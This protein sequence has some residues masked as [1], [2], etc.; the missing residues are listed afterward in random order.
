MEENRLVSKT[1]LPDEERMESALRPKFLSEYIG[2]NKAKEKLEIF[3][4][5]AKMR[6]EALDHVLLSGPPGLGKT[7]LANIIANEMQVNIRVTS[8][9]AIERPGDLASILTNLDENDVLFI[10]EI[11]RIPRTVEE[12]LYPAM[13]DFALDII[14]GK[15]PSARS[16]RLD[17][18]RFTLIGATTRSGQL[19]SPLRDRFGVLL[20]LDLYDPDSLKH[21]LLRSSRILGIPL[22]EKGALEIA[23][24]S[25]GTP[26]IANRLLKRIRDFAEVKRDG[27]ID[28]TV[29]EEGLQLLDVDAYGL[30]DLDRRILDTMIRD[31][32]G[33]PVGIDAIAA[34]LGEERI[35][36]EDV[37]EPYLL[38]INFV[39][40]TPRGR[41]ATKKAYEHLGI[42]FTEEEI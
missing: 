39:Q 5:A 22:S 28:E 41:V 35:T 26:R 19:A 32:G 34:T 7:T 31:Y 21:I 15:G 18:N 2:Q 16:L 17:L 33:R 1:I 29:A 6:N 14:V 9:P 24:R 11:H 42:P 4:E 10:D 30:D 23:K 37:Y 36:I 25:R 3:T 27:L 12:V 40:R 13:E 20:N 8:G 38:Q